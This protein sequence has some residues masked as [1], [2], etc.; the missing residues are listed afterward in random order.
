[1]A[2][3]D[4]KPVT[5]Q[6]LL[7]SSLAQTDALAKLLIEKGLISR[8]RVFPSRRQPTALCTTTTI[9]KEPHCS[10]QCDKR[11]AYPSSYRA[12]RRCGSQECRPCDSGSLGKKE[13]HNNQGSYQHQSNHG[14]YFFHI[15]PFVTSRSRLTPWDALAL[16]HNS[17]RVEQTKGCL[18]HF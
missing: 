16:Y 13:P 5:L 4:K 2:E 12:H 17:S 14:L 6:E 3:S 11:I 15:L 8:A 9:R 7:V 10:S 1:M 18:V